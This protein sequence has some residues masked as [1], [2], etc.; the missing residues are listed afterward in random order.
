M[1]GQEGEQSYVLRGGVE[2]GEVDDE[3]DEDM[4]VFED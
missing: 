2:G 4:G 3:R 1:Y